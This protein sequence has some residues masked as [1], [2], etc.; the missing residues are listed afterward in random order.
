MATVLTVGDNVAGRC[1]P[2]ARQR[3]SAMTDT[4]PPEPTSLKLVEP[5]IEPPDGFDA[6]YYFIEPSFDNFDLSGFRTYL[7]EHFPGGTAWNADQKTL[8]IAPRDEKTGKFHIR[9]RWIVRSKTVDFR[10]DYITG[11]IQHA[12]DET[13]PY[14]EDFMNWFGQFFKNQTTQAHIHCYFLLDA[15]RYTSRVPLPLKFVSIPGEPEMDGVSL[16][17]HE[18]PSGVTQMRLS[19]RKKQWSVEVVGE[20]RIT[21]KTSNAPYGDA[22]VLTK[23]VRTILEAQS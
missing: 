16:R 9:F 18:K 21:L 23:V 4:K 17:F 6:L 1:E 5:S 19:T 3:L 14:A 22:R 7:R 2:S 15:S 20:R 11:T 13:D 8:T 12:S 10:V